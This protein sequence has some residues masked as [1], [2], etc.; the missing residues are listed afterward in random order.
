[1]R[2]S[3]G[4]LSDDLQYYRKLEQ[5]MGQADSTYI[6]S[7]EQK[8]AKRDFYDHVIKKHGKPTTDEEWAERRMAQSAR[9][10]LNHEVNPGWGTRASRSVAF[11]IGAGAAAIGLFAWRVLKAPFTGQPVFRSQQPAVQRMAARPSPVMKPVVARAGQ[12]KQAVLK[13]LDLQAPK[14]VAPRK[15]QGR[16]IG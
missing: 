4:S 15:K 5:K 2:Q 14:K 7:R 13:K 16:R 3:K 1:M 10:K 9:K 11:G 8:A 6:G 12:A